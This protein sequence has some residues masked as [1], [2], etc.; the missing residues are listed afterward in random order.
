MSLRSKAAEMEGL[1]GHGNYTIDA[2]LS[3]LLL[4]FIVS[5]A[6][7]VIVM[8]VGMLIAASVVSTSISRLDLDSFNAFVE[9]VRKSGVNVEHATA[10][11]YTV[12]AGAA[13]ALN[14]TT[15][16]VEQLNAV[17]AH[18]KI[19]LGLTGGQ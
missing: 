7:L 11:A 13:D 19:T 9:S 16:A 4:V 2:R 5:Q 12:A 14:H 15:V 10:L 6:V 8:L 17:L 3:R 18:P 1:N